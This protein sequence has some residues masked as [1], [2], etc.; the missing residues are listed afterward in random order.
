[1]ITAWLVV[2]TVF[3]GVAGCATFGRRGPTA[4]KVAACRELSRQGISAMET[5]QWQRAE[6]LLQQALEASPNDAEA[7]R[8]L[9][10]VLWHRGAGPQAMQHLAAA[11]R[12]RPDDARLA[13]RAGEM[14]LAAGD[15]A[16]AMDH[17]EQAIRLNPQLAVA[18]ALRGRIFWQ[19]QQPDRALADMQRALEF[20]PDS[21][22]VL[23]D[24]A[25]M[26]RERGQSVRC[27][28]TLRH[29]QDTYPPGEEPQNA[30]VLE[31]LTLLDLGRP[32]QACEPFLAATARGPASAQVLY[33]LARAQYAAGRHTEATT[34]VQQALAIDASHEASRQLLAQ[35][36]AHT[37]PQEPKRR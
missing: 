25:V 35:L 34:A 10:E 12:A 23:L 8:S 31:G 21:A 15:R 16:A 1:V 6:M 2:G 4:E 7:R 9:A 30:L 26:Y 29:L 5:G 19:L 33:Y 11:L 27:L 24:V 28:T 37:L 18:W 20:A 14:A 3:P 13:A 22:D 32:Q 17:A 36:A